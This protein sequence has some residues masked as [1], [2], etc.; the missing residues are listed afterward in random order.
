MTFT[1]FSF[2]IFL[3]VVFF[4]HWLIPHRFRWF[5]LLVS[6]LYF[7]MSWNAK[8]IVLILFTMVVSYV[9]GILLER[10]T[11]PNYKKWIIAGCLVACLGVLFVFK[12]MNWLITLLNGAFAQFRIPI[13]MGTLSLLLPVGISFYTFQTLSYVID[14]YRGKIKA[15]HHFGI[16]ATFITFFPQLVAGP[17]ER[18]D[19]LLPQIRRERNFQYEQATYGMILMS[20]GFFK[21]VAI[22]DTLGRYAD[23]IFNSVP[24]KAGL[25]II[26]GVLCFTI[27]IYCDFSGYSDIAI[28]TAKL[29]GIDLCRNFRSPYFSRSIKE[30]W[31]RWHISLSTWFRDY[32]YIPLGGSR[33]S[34][35]KNCRNLIVTFL[36][37]GLWH[38]AGLHYVVWGALHGLAQCGE[39]FLLPARKNHSKIWDA[40]SVVLVFIFCN[41]AWIFFRAETTQDALWMIA[42]MFDGIS[43]PV[44]YLITG[45]RQSGI[46]DKLDLVS[47]FLA[48]AVLAGFDFVDSK[49]DCIELLKKQ[50]LLLRWSVYIVLSVVW[51]Y[52][53]IASFAAETESNFIYFQF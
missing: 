13:Q 52:A 8:Y 53:W 11:N 38:G 47:I 29:F 45:Y 7:Y 5:L 6:S 41:F 18:T 32:V 49:Q 46:S 27:Q 44:S 1:D 26:F 22:A 43:S 23:N 15:E 4:L 10:E 21:K 2:F 36:L 20:W 50:N 35:A 34:T 12:Y 33:C 3:P 37:S 39:K 28:G 14:V 40:L 9:C 42:H 48:L 16:Y 24:E 51:I 17:I 31:S 19:S 25:A 30:F